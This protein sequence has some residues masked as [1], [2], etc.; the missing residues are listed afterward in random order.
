MRCQL[1]VMLTLARSSGEKIRLRLSLMRQG[2]PPMWA[3]S[4]KSFVLLKSGVSITDKTASRF[5]LDISASRY[6]EPFLPIVTLSLDEADAKE[7]DN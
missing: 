5:S 6:K 2:I 3:E 4:K 7:I 1:R